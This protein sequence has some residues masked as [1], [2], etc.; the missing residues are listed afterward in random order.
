ML[1]VNSC[2]NRDESTGR[3]IEG[4]WH[5]SSKPQEEDSSIN[6]MVFSKS[7]PT[8]K[9][10]MQVIGEI[11]TVLQAITHILEVTSSPGSLENKRWYHALE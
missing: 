10:D 1:C 4:F 7:K 3:E 11:V 2:I 6:D 5:T 8:L 9:L